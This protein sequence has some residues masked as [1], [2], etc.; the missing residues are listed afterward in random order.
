MNPPDESV[1]AVRGVSRTFGRTRALDDVSLDVPRGIVLGLVGENGAGKTTLLKHVLGLLRAERGS[2]R[3]FGLDPVREPVAVLGRIGYLSEDR[4]LP[5]WMRVGEL[6]QYHRAFYADWDDRLAS[7]LLATFELPTGPRVKSLSRG[8]RARVGLLLALAH[9]PPL[10]ILDEPSSGLDPIVRRDILEAIIRTVSDEGRNVLFSSHLL[11][12]VERVSDR[13]VM[14]HAGR[15]RLDGS[16]DELLAAHRRLVVRFAAPQTAPPSWP[17]ALH[18]SGAGREWTVLV[19]GEG[20][21]LRAAAVAAQAEIVSEE[22]ATLD[23]IFV[24]RVSER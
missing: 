11:D 9:R 5:D 18:W 7:E 14:L 22:G 10:L 16:V 21:S 6:L 1:V 23:E 8:Q 4:D 24:G 20:A 12:E 2:V 3:V 15:I 19:N 13:V 17:G